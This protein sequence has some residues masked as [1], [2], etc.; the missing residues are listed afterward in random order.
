[1]DEDDKTGVLGCSVALV[2]IGALTGAVVWF[3]NRDVPPEAE[4]P[5]AASSAAV[6]P[7]PVEKKARAPVT[8]VS[9]VREKTVVAKAA[10]LDP[11][12]RRIVVQDPVEAAAPPAAGVS[13]TVQDLGQV[14]KDGP[15]PGA[16]QAASDILEMEQL[17]Y[18]GRIARRAP[19]LFDPRGFAIT[20]GADDFAG[21]NPRPRLEFFFH[22]P[23]AP[24]VATY[25]SMTD[26][27]V[28]GFPANHE[29]PV[30]YDEGAIHTL[31]ARW[32]AAVA[33]ETC[34]AAKGPQ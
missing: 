17:C 26:R 8:Q 31:I 32:I 27:D 5:A 15:P 7:P 13:A 22:P 21:G 28:P 30:V 3:V 12:A 6:T 18:E 25:L 23:E 10:D 16:V 20:Y 19:S 11:L 33:T 4:A 1:M 24:T 34:P 9:P 29:M 2:V 14:T